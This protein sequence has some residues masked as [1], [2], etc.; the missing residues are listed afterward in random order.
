MDA[1][2]RG[3]RGPLVVAALLAGALAVAGGGVL[4]AMGGGE[5]PDSG[6]GEVTV[7]DAWTAPNQDATAVYLTFDNDGPD[8]RL[9]GASTEIAETTSLM[10]TDEGISHRADGVEAVRLELPS[11]TTELHAGGQHLMLEGLTRRLAPG[12]SFP[13]ELEL[14]DAG[15]VTATVEVVPWDE[16]ASRSGG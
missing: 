3:S 14:R 1:R 13:L 5:E 16:A 9:A 11:G 12:D 15:R 8:D 2:Q 4:L 6:G 7:H 10:G